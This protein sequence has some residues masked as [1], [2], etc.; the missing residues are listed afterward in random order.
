MWS[1]TLC[2]E[3]NVLTVAGSSAWQIWERPRCS[4]EVASGIYGSLG[5][6]LDGFHFR[7]CADQIPDSSDLGLSDLKGTAPKSNATSAALE[8]KQSVSHARATLGLPFVFDAGLLFERVPPAASPVY[9]I[10]G[11]PADLGL[12]FSPE[13]GL[14]YGFPVLP[15]TTFDDS[16]EAGEPGL[17]YSFEITIFAEEAAGNLLANT[18]LEIS[19]FDEGFSKSAIWQL[20]T[21][22]SHISADLVPAGCVLDRPC[23]ID[24]KRSLLRGALEIQDID[25]AIYGFLGSLSLQ[26]TMS[27]LGISLANSSGVLS[28][29]SG[30]HIDNVDEAEVSRMIEHRRR[31]LELPMPL[32]IDVAAV[33][34]RG[35]IYV[36]RQLLTLDTPSASNCRL[37][38]WELKETEDFV[39]TE[40]N[41]LPVK[42]NTKMQPNREK[43]KKKKKKYIKKKKA[44]LKKAKGRSSARSLLQVFEGL[45]KTRHETASTCSSGLVPLSSNEVLT[46][47]R[48]SGS[49]APPPSRPQLKCSPFP[50]TFAQ[51]TTTCRGMG[52]RLCSRDELLAAAFDGSGS[53]QNA[54]EI[55]ACMRTGVPFWSSTICDLAVPATNFQSL[56]AVVIFGSSVTHQCVD[57]SARRHVYCCADRGMH[58]N[59]IDIDSTL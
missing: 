59:M 47:Y 12:R 48:S 16:E 20:A 53:A 42:S 33:T 55:Q 21:G 30:G 46:S 36:G 52:A 32:R 10:I 43:K 28:I 19:Y 8:A 1:G 49:A 4:E 9:F 58:Q 6:E 24:L 44:R 27:K 26:Q 41:D 22:K 25:S 7:C 17:L 18:T 40:I 34:K 3:R 2:G 31:L 11:L 39:Q 50:V 5:E 38:G 56:G 35:S 54:P 37:L 45:N 57:F 23:R 14:L 51:A 13:E 15:S 29:S